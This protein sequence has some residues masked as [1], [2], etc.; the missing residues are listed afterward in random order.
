[1]IMSRNVCAV[2]MTTEVKELCPGGVVETEMVLLERCERVEDI[3][4]DGA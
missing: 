4:K 3:G 1:M 2:A